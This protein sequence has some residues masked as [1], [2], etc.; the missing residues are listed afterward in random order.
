M[1]LILS[2]SRKLAFS[3]CSMLRG[4]KPGFSISCV[5]DASGRR[6][7]SLIMPTMENYFKY[8]QSRKPDF[9][10]K[11]P[12]NLLLRRKIGQSLLPRA[13]DYLAAPEHKM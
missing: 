8:S 12:P 13:P 5:S 4:F 6:C 3:S 7:Q 2:T 1:C 10:A 11:P 9:R